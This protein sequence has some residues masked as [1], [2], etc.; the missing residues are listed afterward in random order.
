MKLVIV[1]SKYK[2]HTL[3]K[4]LG[5]DY[6]VVACDGH[7]R[8]LATSG[9]NGYGVDI[10]NGF[11]PKF[12]IDEKKA[13]VIKEL[14]KKANKSEEVILAS[15]DDRE[16]EAIA[17]HLAQVLNLDVDTAK[18]LRF[19]EITRDSIGEAIKSPDKI[20][21]NRVE[22]QET[23]RIID[24]ILGFGLSKITKKA[25]KS[26]SAGRVQSATLKILCDREKEINDFK[27]E[28]FWKLSL[29][30]KGKSLKLTPV[31][32]KGKQYPQ[33][34]TEALANEILND[35]GD[36][37]KVT[38]IEWKERV[39]KSK[40]PF[41]TA[42]LQQE[43]FNQLGFSSSKTMRVAQELYEGIT[44]GDEPVGLITYM[45]T[46]SAKLSNSFI[47]RAKAFIIET[48]GENYYRGAKAAKNSANAQEAHEAIR[49]TGNHR[50]PE[51]IKEFLTNDQY[52]LY[53]LI[54][55]RALASVMADKVDDVCTY[56][57][58]SN[59]CVVKTSTT[60]VKFDGFSKVYSI[61]E[62]EEAISKKINLKLDEQIEVEDKHL[63]TDFTKPPARFT[64]ASIVK[65]MD[66]VGIG[67]PSTYAPTIDNLKNRNYISMEKGKIIPS[68][69]GMMTSYF[70]G[71]N[72]PKF[73]ETKYTADLE[74]ELDEIQKGE[75]KR[76]DV[77]N[78]FYSGYLKA[79]EEYEK[80][81]KV[82]VEKPEPVKTGHICP[83]CGHDLVIRK[84]KYGEFEA[85]S[86]YPKCKY[87]VKTP[88][89][90]PEKV[91]RSC[92][93]CGSELVFRKGKKGTFI[94]CS[95]FPKCDYHEFAE[96]KDEEN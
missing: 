23:R 55:N 71:G 83:V 48:F 38:N 18:R 35:V 94:G 67:R 95:N 57:L 37:F 51:S 92:P 41:T 74:T 52:K 93:K 68:E 17:W 33:I 89:K 9:K 84:G 25:L 56:T 91:G 5:E 50:T 87:V 82:V 6:D 80:N 22:S 62:E 1:E 7:I 28:Q 70:L 19:H 14:T 75:E 88:K 53:T 49:H 85:C 30:L 10:E 42:T 60:N 21:M 36:K 73:V 45:R 43:A 32:Y 58:T 61:E 2:T 24:R 26:E 12:V 59:N 8:D 47:N 63:E 34:P 78:S 44:I 79:I 66:E 16:G 64:V 96:Q 20:D 4:Y 90:E 31:S 65:T 15:D 81:P 3:K 54:Y 11:A 39:T 13:D 86:N 69:Q 72:F 27:P 46:D 76:I 29:K 77:L 40:E